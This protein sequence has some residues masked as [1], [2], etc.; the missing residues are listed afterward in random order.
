[1]RHCWGGW[2]NI[3]AAAWPFLV[4]FHRYR[5]G[6][7][8][9][10]FSS[11]SF[12]QHSEC[13]GGAR[14]SLWVPSTICAVRYETSSLWLW[15]WLPAFWRTTG[16]G[17]WAGQFRVASPILISAT[18]RPRAKCH[19]GPR[20]FIW[21]PQCTVGIMMSF[22]WF[23]FFLAFHSHDDR[24][25]HCTSELVLPRCASSVQVSIVFRSKSLCLESC[26][27]AFVLRGPWKSECLVECG[28]RRLVSAFL[29]TTDSGSQK[30]RRCAVWALTTVHFAQRR[31][32]W[33]WSYQP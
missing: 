18:A 3:R 15:G 31:L 8:S 33:S 10:D 23:F 17:Q 30:K 24:G 6:N 32:N 25:R 26:R 20:K 5:F 4:L 21:V 22:S 9:T 14:T 27:S 29:R 19:P 1:M 12:P 16:A 7:F 2:P 28:E 13:H 11:C